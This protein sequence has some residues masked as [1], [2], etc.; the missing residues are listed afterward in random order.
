MT[1]AIKSVIICNCQVK[2]Q[3]ITVAAASNLVAGAIEISG[4]K[5]ST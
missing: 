2:L 3:I 5:L 4:T 1:N